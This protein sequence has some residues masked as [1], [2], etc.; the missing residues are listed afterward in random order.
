MPRSMR[1]ILSSKPWL[2]IVLLLVV[3]LAGWVFFITIAVK[4]APKSVPVHSTPP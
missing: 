3:F 4:N 1:K 2:L